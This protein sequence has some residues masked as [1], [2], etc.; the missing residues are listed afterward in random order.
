VLVLG[1]DGLWESFSPD[2]SAMYGKERLREVIRQSA[3][4]SAQGI[5]D[6]I[7]AD[8]REFLDGGTQD[9]DVTLVVVRFE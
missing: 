6:A 2:G 9:D 4:L 7:T 5:L 1:T 8:W 3:S